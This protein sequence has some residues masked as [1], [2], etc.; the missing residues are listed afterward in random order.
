MV[1]LLNSSA[2][3]KNITLNNSVPEDTIAYADPNMLKTILRNLVQNSI[4]FTKSGGTVDIDSV[5]KQNQIILSVTD[6]GVGINEEKETYNNLFR[7]DTISITNGTEH[8]RGSGL[9]LVLCKEF[10]ERN[11]GKIWAES[12]AGKGCKFE[13]TIPS[14]Q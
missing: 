5:L 11:G 13:F 8:E 14:S 4:K 3:L 12:E 7:I 1:G 10:V 2:T 9:G 6:N